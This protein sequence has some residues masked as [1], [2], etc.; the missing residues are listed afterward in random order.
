MGFAEKQSGKDG[1]LRTTTE[2]RTSFKDFM[3][4]QMALSESNETWKGMCESLQ[5]QSHG[6]AAR[7]ASAYAHQVATP[8]SERLSIK[9]APVGAF[10]FVDDPNDSNRF[11]HIVGKWAQG[12]TEADTPVVTNDVTD[13]QSGYDPGNVTVCPLG[14]FPTHWGDNIRFATV[15]FGSDSIPLKDDKPP[16]S[17]QQDTRDWIKRSIERAELVIE[18]M[19]KAIKD[20]DGRKHPKHEAALKR[21]VEDQRKII[22]DLKRLL[23]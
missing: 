19:K 1:P 7:F 3:R 14:W 9:E 17:A 10:I 15:W 8:R 5:R 23:P 4:R 12:E 11:G 22:A 18:L 20:N 16:E 13:S 6:F 2:A 21:E